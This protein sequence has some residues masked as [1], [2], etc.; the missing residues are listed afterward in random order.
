MFEALDKVVFMFY[1][2]FK[3]ILSF[4]WNWVVAETT[5]KKKLKNIDSDLSKIKIDICNKY[6]FYII[7]YLKLFLNMA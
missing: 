2:K 3:Y 4:I 5:V 7:I 1:L 6:D